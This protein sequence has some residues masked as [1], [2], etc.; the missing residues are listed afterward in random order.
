MR[1]KATVVAERLSLLRRTV[2]LGRQHSR[3]CRGP[4]G[5]RSFTGL[6]FT[7]LS[8]GNPQASHAQRG[9]G[10]APRGGEGQPQGG[11]ARPPVTGLPGPAQGRRGGR[12][13]GGAGHQALHPARAQVAV[14]VLLRTQHKR[15]V[16]RV[17]Y[18]RHLSTRFL[19]PHVGCRD[20]CN[21]WVRPAP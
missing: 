6:T 15:S 17:R 8:G 1:T 3:G 5:A 4:A 7:A 20:A 21:L 18:H 10:T 13:V 11:E 16:L 2:N 9:A 12:D 19:P 14:T